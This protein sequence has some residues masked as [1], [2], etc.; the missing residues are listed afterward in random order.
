MLQWYITATQIF[1]LPMF[2]GKHISTIVE[3]VDNLFLY[4]IVFAPL[5][6]GYN[7]WTGRSWTCCF[8]SD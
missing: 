4:K 3:S 8:F 1:C 7:Q 5:G 6:M 2:F